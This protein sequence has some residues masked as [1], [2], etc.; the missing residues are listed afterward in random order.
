MRDNSKSDDGYD[1]KVNVIKSK[2][3]PDM[4]D[5]RHLIVCP[6]CNGEDFE[7]IYVAGKSVLSW[8]R[9]GEIKFRW[10][11]NKV[12]SLRCLQCDYILNFARK[13]PRN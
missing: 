13:K 3:E 1:I 12:Q 2:S 8:A 6:I 9:L 10:N 4:I 7:D 11:M 5:P